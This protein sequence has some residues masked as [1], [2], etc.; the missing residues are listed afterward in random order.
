MAVCVSSEGFDVGMGCFCEEHKP[1]GAMM[2]RFCDE[3]G[4]NMVTPNNSPGSRYCDSHRKKSKPP[5]PAW[6][7]ECMVDDCSSIAVFGLRDGPKIFCRRHA[8]PGMQTYKNSCCTDPAC[9]KF[10]TFG[11][12]ETGRETCGKHRR[13]D[14]VSFN[15]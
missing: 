12:L 5:R 14:M 3:P 10:P 8:L 6:R 13:D 11:Y 2:V 15:K 1:E 4:C 7:L 9:M